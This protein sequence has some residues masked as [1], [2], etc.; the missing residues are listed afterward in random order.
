MIKNYS[1]LIQHLPVRQQSETTKRSTWK[2]AEK[3]ISWLMEFN[4]NLFGD[5]ETLILSRQDI[6]NAT[7]STRDLILKT[8]YWGYP[9]NMRGNHFV[10]I[11]HNIEP[12]EMAINK[13][14]SKKNLTDNDFE[15]LKNVFKT[16]PG[17]GLST[18]SKLLYFLNFKINGNPCLILDQRL[19][20]AI[21]GKQFSE[22]FSL[23]PLTDYNKESK[24]SEFLKITNQLANDLQTEGEN[25][26]QFLF[27]YGTNL[28]PSTQIV[29]QIW[30]GFCPES[31]L[32]GKHV[33]MRLNS[34]DL[35]ESE[36]TGLQIS[37]LSGV[38]AI[39]LKV[40]GK[41]KFR[42]IPKFAD[43]IENGE[44]LS[45]QNMD[46]PPFNSPTE[47]FTESEQIKNYI[48]AFK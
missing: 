18:Y 47:V 20:D 37:V 35:F 30:D 36:E 24:Y 7:S 25:I 26:E 15:E 13:L 16:I 45:P 31:L 42:S 48:R 12:L 6:L 38:Q 32:N 34:S 14:K 22:Y 2:K 10:N 44:F 5:S 41:G 4:N 43:E 28:K 19:I 29:S 27:T 8:I 40:R 1:I 46:R 21:N 23:K 39:I 9:I 11:M 3:E 33:R 17:L